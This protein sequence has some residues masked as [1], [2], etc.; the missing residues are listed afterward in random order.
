MFRHDIP[1]YISAGLARRWGLDPSMCAVSDPDTL[2]GR[3][4]PNVQGFSQWKTTQHIV[5]GKITQKSKKERYKAMYNVR[6]SP[7]QMADP[8]RRYKK[9]F[10]L[11]AGK[12]HPRS[13]KGG[14]GSAR[15]L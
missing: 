14:G 5:G 9:R 11:S 6:T 13:L 4:H 1:V 10:H 3:S 8:M 7:K 15:R 12:M 2:D